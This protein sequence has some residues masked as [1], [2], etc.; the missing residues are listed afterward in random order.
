[1]SLK[2]FFIINSICCK[3]VKRKLPAWQKN[4]RMFEDL[5]PDSLHFT[6]VLE[7]FKFVISYSSIVA[8]RILPAAGLGDQ[9]CAC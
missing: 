9:K 8:K 1:M 5:F 6:V 3:L 4:L 2:K 7:T